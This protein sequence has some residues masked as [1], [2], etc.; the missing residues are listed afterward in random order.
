MA[1]V[2]PR[3]ASGFGPAAEAYE[4]GRPSYP[5]DA[6]ERLAGALGLDADSEVLDLA[7]GTGKLTR[8]LLPRFA[9][10]VAV[11]PSDGMLDVLRAELPEAEV[12]TGTA[13]SIPLPDGAVDAVFVA[14]AFHWFGTEA[15][16]REIARVLRPGGGLGLL[17]NRDDW[18][19]FPWRARFDALTK[20]Y[21]AAAGT[22]PAE[23]WDEALAASGRFGAL[24]SADIEHV[25]AT[26]GAGLVDLVAS[27]SWIA[28]LPESER[29]ALLAGVAGLVAPDAPLD[30]TYRTEVEWAPLV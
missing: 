23:D 29:A 11:D 30:L 15:V 4:R 14:E 5:P 28:N 12:R 20:P 9:R 25:H 16:C 22:F 19:P 3:A 17:W 27:W 21:R 18:T 6:V 13:A 1:T 10:V 8:V 24:G 26:T 2:D 7:A